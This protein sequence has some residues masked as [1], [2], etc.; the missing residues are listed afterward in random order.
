MTRAWNSLMELSTS[1]VT[2][3]FCRA[4]Q[5]VLAAGSAE[6]PAGPDRLHPTFI[7]TW[8]CPYAQRTWIALNAKGIEFTPIFVDLMNKPEWFFKHN[9]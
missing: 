2:P 8:S 9:P 6:P 3:S 1:L 4:P 5:P 7:T